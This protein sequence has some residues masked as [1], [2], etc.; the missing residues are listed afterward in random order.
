MKIFI[1]YCHPSQDSFTKN[2]C[3]AFIKGIT[4]SGNEYIMSDLYKMDFNP[5][6]TEQEYLRDANY[7]IFPEVASDVLA[8]QEKI[9]SAD[10]IAFIY[11]VFWTEAPARL[12]G[13]FDRVW[14]YGFAYGDKTMK[15]LDKA[16]ILC[17]AGNPI[18]K[19]EQFGLLDSMKKVMLGDRLYGRAKQLEFVVFDNTSR[20]NEL[21]TKKWESNLQKA[22]EKGKTFFDP[23][24]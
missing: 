8:E 6:M 1:V 2:M 15:L 14:S 24:Y 16:I 4:D 9:N 11:P 19:L 23:C 20:E 21:R 22:Y 10:A 5:V 3:D 18:E 7:R 13:W 17:S 12:V